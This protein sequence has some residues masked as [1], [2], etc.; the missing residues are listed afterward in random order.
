MYGGR[1]DGKNGDVK[2]QISV[3]WDDECT[4]EI[5]VFI[6]G[7]N[8]STLYAM[9]KLAENHMLDVTARSMLRVYPYIPFTENR[10]GQA[11]LTVYINF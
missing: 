6:H 7:Q 8:V 1:M 11:S 5:Q 2:Y 9:L 4:Y 10:R 3:V